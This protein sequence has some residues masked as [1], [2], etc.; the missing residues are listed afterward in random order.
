MR[1]IRLH[2]LGDVG[3]EL[4]DE[5]SSLATNYQDG[6]CAVKWDTM[7]A[8]GD[9]GITL[10]Y[11]FH[12]AERKGWKYSTGAEADVGLGKAKS[13]GGTE[14]PIVNRGGFWVSCLHNSLLWLAEKSPAITVRY[15][16]FRQVILIDDRPMDDEA[17]ISLT[18]QLETSKR[19]AWAQEHVRSALV[20]LAHRNEYSSLTA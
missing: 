11:L 17:V 7:S 15:D 9:S 8:A 6:A 18:A 14:Q 3:L 13:E 20:E 16:R 12:H 4:W 2:E 10:D 1:G 19:A 5:W